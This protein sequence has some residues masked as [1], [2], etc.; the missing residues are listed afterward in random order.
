MKIYYAILPVGYTEE[1]YR[2]LE[3]NVND[4]RLKDEYLY[5][6]KNYAEFYIKNVLKENLENYHIL[7]VNEHIVA[8]IARSI[9]V[10][11]YE[12]EVEI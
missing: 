3:Q 7:K 9:K 6:Y 10:L 5:K 1:D 12:I 2:T 8:T 11:R 4:E